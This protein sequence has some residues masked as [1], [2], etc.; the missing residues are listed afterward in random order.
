MYVLKNIETGEI[1]ES[2]KLSELS[3]K[4]EYSRSAL[5]QILKGNYDH[6]SKFN[7][8]Y[9]ISLRQLPKPEKPQKPE[10]PYKYEVINL[11]VGSYKKYKNFREMAS[12][13]NECLSE[14]NG[15]INGTRKS[16]KYIIRKIEL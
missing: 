15:L 4:C 13:I 1:F 3:T 16:K 14:I 12:D 5:G 10:K 9:E 6:K 8:K 7:N 11:E 2:P